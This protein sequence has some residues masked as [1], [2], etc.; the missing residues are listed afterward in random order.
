MDPAVEENLLQLQRAGSTSGLL[1]LYFLLT[2][3]QKAKS[4]SGQ[5][6]GFQGYKPWGWDG[7]RGGGALPRDQQ[8]RALWE[9]L[10]IAEVTAHHAGDKSRN[11]TLFTPVSITACNRDSRESAGSL[12]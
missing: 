5:P 8:S 6:G 11:L 10:I 9:P 2:P 7:V 12:G 3:C 4:V 1:G